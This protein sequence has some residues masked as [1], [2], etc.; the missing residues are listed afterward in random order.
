MGNTKGFTGHGSDDTERF[1]AVAGFGKGTEARLLL[2]KRHEY[3]LEWLNMVRVMKNL[4]TRVTNTVCFDKKS[5]P[6]SKNYG[7]MEWNGKT[8]PMSRM[9]CAHGC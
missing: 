2:K 4:R 7:S 6:W 1:H 8:R 3:R 9:V 5:N